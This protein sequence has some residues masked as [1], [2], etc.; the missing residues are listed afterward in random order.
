MAIVM[1][2]VIT[3]TNPNPNPNPNPVIIIKTCRDIKLLSII[4]FIQNLPINI[5]QHLKI[6]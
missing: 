4:P 6:K 2:I 3:L 1:L 5:R